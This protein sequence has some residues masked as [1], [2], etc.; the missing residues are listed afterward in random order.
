M[1]I[2]KVD[3]VKTLQSFV[4]A[5]ETKKLDKLTKLFTSNVACFSPDD[6]ELLDDVAAAVKPM[7]QRLA[8]K[9]ND[10]AANLRSAHTRLEEF[11]PELLGHIAS[12][13]PRK[14]QH[15][16]HLVSPHIRE[17]LMQPEIMTY[18]LDE[19]LVKFKAQDLL[20]FLQKYGQ[21]VTRLNLRKFRE[22]CD[23]KLLEEIIKYC[24]N[25]KQLQIVC[26]YKNYGWEG[27][28]NPKI[29]D[30]FLEYLMG[31]KALKDLKLVDFTLTK[32]TLTELKGFESLESLTLEKCCIGKDSL[33]PLQGAASLKSLALYAFGLKPSESRKTITQE[34]EHLKSV[35]TLEHLDITAN[36]SVNIGDKGFKF[37]CEIKSLR[38]LSLHSA[39]ISDQGLSGLSVLESLEHLDLSYC[40]RITSE[41][42]KHIAALSP[43]LQYLDLSGCEKISKN[44]I[45]DF[46][47]QYP[48]M[49]IVEH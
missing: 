17:C 34:V 41:G 21:L 7:N 48:E 15:R 18:V 4:Q 37:I 25:L 10:V 5:P 32:D 11:P 2:S 13:L 31:L 22:E 16:L 24:P 3:I 47:N 8:E 12:F 40:D 46:R 26:H 28:T 6:A 35:E 14:E 29:S 49:T 45:E 43:K 44:E 39:K 27:S 20:L 1:T 38:Q 19:G 23:D 36:N 9:I 33:I 30:S 42:L